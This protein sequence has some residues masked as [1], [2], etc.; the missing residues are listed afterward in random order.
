MPGPDKT[1]PRDEA[2]AI[3]ARVFETAGERR[4]HG[5]RPGRGR[6]RRTEGARV[7]P[8]G[9]LRGTA[10]QRQ[11]RRHPSADDRNQRRANRHRRRLRPGLSR[12]RP[13]ARCASRARTRQRRRHGSDPAFA[14]LRAA[15]RTCRKARRSRMHRAHGRQHAQGDGPLGRERGPVRHEPDRLRRAA[16]RAS[17][18][19]H[20]PVAVQGRPWQDHGRRQG[21]R[22]DPRRLGTGRG[23]QPDEATSFSMPRVP[24]PVS[25]R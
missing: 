18:T 2:E 6:D 16:R 25:A 14:S 8:R 7:L 12:H 11:D 17:A 9:V 5:A 15:W 13:G 3:V 4:E 24:P 21:R 22:S 10:A 20:R 23:R 1:L 19:G